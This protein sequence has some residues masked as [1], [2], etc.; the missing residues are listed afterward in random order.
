MKFALYC[1]DHPAKRKDTMKFLLLSALLAVKSAYAFYPD[2]I[3]GP[4]PPNDRDGDSKYDIPHIFFQPNTDV[5]TIDIGSSVP[6]DAPSLV[7][8]ASAMT[9]FSSSDVPSDMPSLV[10]SALPS[11]LPSNF[12]TTYVPPTSDPTS[13]PTDLVYGSTFELTFPDRKV[14]SQ[15]R[16]DQ[17]KVAPFTRRTDFLRGGGR[18]LANS[19][20]EEMDDPSTF[21]S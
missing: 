6:S 12:P 2:G 20:P 11:D 19:F 8:S 17:F 1:G 7:P 21:R 4:D 14:P 10:P 16:K 9:S 18:K 3:D 15:G 13:E 5:S